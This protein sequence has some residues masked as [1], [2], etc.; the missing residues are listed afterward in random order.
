MVLRILPVLLLTLILS[1]VYLYFKFMYG[2]R[3]PLWAY[4]LFFLPNALLL[5]AAL[6]LTWTE[7]H[8]PENMTQMVIFFSLY[9]LIALPKMLFLIV[10]LIGKGICLFFPRAKKACTMVSSAASLLLLCIMGAGLSFGPTLLQVR[11]TNF[12]SAD[13][14]T[15]FASCSSA[16]CTS[17]VSETG[18]KWWRRSWNASWNNVP[19]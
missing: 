14:P 9:M 13:L 4:F 19:T 11:H 7:N 1:D 18:R 6:I 10:D 15:A 16:T 2:R 12:S 5:I 17:Q 8:T 3:H